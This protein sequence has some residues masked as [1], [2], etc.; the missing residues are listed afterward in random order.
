MERIASN[1]YSGHV[2]DGGLQGHSVSHAYPWIVIGIGNDWQAYNVV[3]DESYPRRRAISEAYRDL[4]V[5]IAVRDATKELMARFGTACR[6]PE[7]VI[8]NAMRRHMGAL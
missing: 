2:G 4:H 6:L 3:T 5:A 8:K 7:A 1:K